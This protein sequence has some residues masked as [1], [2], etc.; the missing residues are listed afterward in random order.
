MQVESFDYGRYGLIRFLTPPFN[1]RLVDRFY[2]WYASAVKSCPS[3]DLESY[4]KRPSVV[5]HSLGSWI[6]GNAMLK[7]EDV[8]FDKLV[9]AG[10][11]LPRDFDWAT[12]FARD[13]VAFV[14]NECGQKDPWPSWASRLVLRAGTGGVEGFEWFGPGVENVR[15][16][17]FGHSDALMRQHIE[18]L[19]VP[20]LLRSPSPLTL[21]H[22]RDIQDGAK[23]LK[24]LD[25]T[26]TIIDGEAFGTLPHYEE[27]EIPRGLSTTWIKVNP[28][29]Y[30]FLIDRQ[31][32]KP[33]GYINAMPV[34]DALYAQ[35]RSGRVLD[36]AI[37]ASSIV[38]F[39]GTEPVKVYLMSIAIDEEYRR[40]GDGVLQQAYV[41]LLTGFLDKLIY[42][43][44]NYGIRATHLLATAWT[45][46][47]RRMC[48]FFTMTEVG[49]DE[50]GDSIFELD[51]RVLQSTQLPRLCPPLRRLLKV[52]EQAQ[53]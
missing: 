5:A 27:A 20:V 39:L 3:A 12:L 8:R 4:D 44:K 26:G 2:N 14:R 17:W 29:I 10:S 21:L 47:G 24:I 33:A 16:E 48:Q 22:G 11:I 19:W 34:D 15:C 43:A 18:K 50:F 6:V 51:L 36:N 38:P 28:D 32:A 31:T 52:Y 9:L 30:T 41:Q 42:Y 25:H 45:P 23:F 7:Y 1:S 46:E 40:W 49:K 53:D 37:P 13:Q 35:I